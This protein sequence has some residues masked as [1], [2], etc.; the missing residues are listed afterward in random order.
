MFVST[1]GEWSFD[2]YIIALDLAAFN[3]NLLANPI[4]DFC[5]IQ[6]LTVLQLI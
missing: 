5:Q 1:S 6:I 3:V 2:F 4:I